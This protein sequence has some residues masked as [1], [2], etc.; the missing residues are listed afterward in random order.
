MLN[1]RFPENVHKG[2][3]SSFFNVQNVMKPKKSNYSLRESFGARFALNA[4]LQEL[5]ASASNS[6]QFSTHSTQTAIYPES[7]N[8]AHSRLFRIV[9]KLVKAGMND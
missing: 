7:L 6:L 4:K 1:P 3:F 2:I 9:S 8:L 5:G